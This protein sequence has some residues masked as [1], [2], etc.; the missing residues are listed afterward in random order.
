MIRRLFLLSFLAS[1]PLFLAADAPAEEPARTAED[2][3]RIVYEQDE[4]TAGRA[5]AL[6]CL[7]R[8]QRIEPSNPRIPEAAA[9]F[10]RWHWSE[11]PRLVPPGMDRRV[12]IR[13]IQ[14][15][16]IERRFE[17]HPADDP[18]A[19][20]E[21][22]LLRLRSGRGW[23][24][25]PVPR[26]GEWR[27]VEEIEGIRNSC[28]LLVR[29][30]TVLARS[31]GSDGLAW[32]ID[33]ESGAPLADAA[34]EVRAG[35]AVTRGR[36]GPDGLFRFPGAPEATVTATASGESVEI[37]LVGTDTDGGTRVYFTTD[38][39]V[40]RPGQTVHYKAVVREMA[41]AGPARGERQ[42]VV[43][44]VRDPRGRI[45]ETRTLALTGAGSASGSFAIPAEPPI[46]DYSLVCRIPAR[47]WQ[48]E[49]FEDTEADGPNHWR[50]TFSVAAYRKPE[51][52]VAVEPAGRE[53]DSYRARIRVAWWT[54]EPARDVRVVWSATALERGAGEVNSWGFEDH[55]LFWLFDEG[56]PY[57]GGGH[58]W[59]GWDE[60][61]LG[62]DEGVTDD[63]GVMEVAVP[64]TG[65]EHLDRIR[66]EVLVGDLSGFVTGTEVELPVAGDTAELAMWTEP[67]FAAPGETVVARARVSG[68]DG[69]PMAGRSVEL[70]A[71]VE[72]PERDDGSVEFEEYFRGEARTGD[73]GAVAFEVPVRAAPRIRLVATA[74]GAAAAVRREIDVAGGEER[75]DREWDAH[76]FLLP[77][78]YVYA[79]GDA[80]RFL[81]EV[82]HP[83][84]TGLL[85]V[86]AGGIER[87]E[88]VRLE[89]RSQ[90]IEVPIRPEYAPNATVFVHGFSGGAYVGGGFEIFVAPTDRLLEVDIA[91]DRDAYRPGEPMRIALETRG[92]NDGGVPAEVEL[93]IVDESVFAV[94]RDLTPDIRRFFSPLRDFAGWSTWATPGDGW[95]IGPSSF[96]AG[97]GGDMEPL[98][99][100]AEEGDAILGGGVDEGGEPLRT[101][102][103][104]TAYFAAHVA[105]GP[106]G[107]ATVELPAPDS[108]A[109]WRLT[110]RAVAG[111]DRFGQAVS[112][113]L[114]RKPVVARIAAP[115]FFT[116]RDRATI[117][118]IV[119]SELA[120][121][122]E[123]EVSLT[124]E[125]IRVGGEPRTVAVEPGGEVRV[126]FPVEADAAGEA[127]LRAR[128]ISAAESDALE[129]R[130]P[131]R[132]HATA[133]R[134]AAAGAGER[135][136]ATLAL[137][138]T[139]SVGDARMKVL[140]TT[141]FDAIEEALP[142]LAGYPYGC[143]EQT[144]SRF[145][146]TVIA[147]RALRRTGRPVDALEAAL[148]E[149][150]AA[151]LA[152][153]YRFQH[154]DGGWGWWEHDDTDPEMTAYVVA[155]LAT[156]R[157]AGWLVDPTTLA[158]GVECLKE[159]EPTAGGAMAL[160]AA[161][162]EPPG[163]AGLEPPNALERAML[164]LAGR[165][166]LAAGLPAAPGDGSGDG[167][168]DGTGG[169]AVRQS[170]LV[171]R[172]L[173]AAD[174][175]DP[176]IP[177]FV[178]DL[179]RRR[180][181]PRWV[182][183]LDSA[184]AV[185]ALTEVARPAPAPRATVRVNGAPAA[186]GA[187]AA[188]RLRP[189]DNR[190]EVDGSPGSV[191][192]VWIDFTDRSAEDVAA[193]EGAF[194]VTRSFDRVLRT[195]DGEEIRP[196]EPGE[197][198]RH[199]DELV[200]RVDVE[201][202][203]GGEFVMIEA[204][205]PAGTEPVPDGYDEEWWYEEWCVRRE[206]RDD[207]VSVAVR[208][209][210]GGES[211]EVRL[212]A[213]V[214]GSYH[215]MPAT[216]RGMY[217][218]DREGRSAEARLVVAPR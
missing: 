48:G 58:G 101:R 46:G 180:V 43:V 199:G 163:L 63:A 82:P 92:G 150:V 62:G 74:D 66:F 159:M 144:M 25:L 127:V 131:V 18:D 125:G 198:V 31:A 195:E 42:E 203:Q 201:A 183:T 138:P 169:E 71:L 37:P 100:V 184:A 116:E 81:V 166:D 45:L 185:H 47:E 13:V 119:R 136:D 99:G 202:P 205:F 167:T 102:F 154:E 27:I 34:V 84:L 204:P 8:L 196:L 191:V 50:K 122:T 89:A 73:D 103:P 106:D 68:P 38:R 181:G 120:A 176:R 40:Y 162:E 165:H 145:L 77:D 20:A 153:L 214:P 114:T 6:E 21:A 157:D 91:A 57:V 35:D 192:A 41:P 7:R 69:A 4:T 52:A 109:A 151:G 206:V 72:A 211:F 16:W 95:F 147:A 115:R 209:I 179:L 49:A 126:E 132:L 59:W 70:R 149:M 80:A 51:L 90:V 28:V 141:P 54:G 9:R 175:H 118:V 22:T 111:A 124:A 32:V 94:A 216:A 190:V 215:V 65:P 79:P 160:A 110:A 17:V 134:V 83:P 172:A 152:R 177:L 173:A 140:V 200:M 75:E 121:R 112:S 53:G 139:A 113:A 39:P 129:V 170:A 44:D 137:P 33:T 15:R 23:L 61:D 174:P 155:G 208:E 194:R 78:R 135:F 14:D 86:V 88:I 29:S 217:A 12:P 24:S 96:R 189:G 5:R 178:A 55:P 76:V 146:P 133:G 2:L 93:A 60:E 36:T 210:Y 19:R 98:F 193:V 104:D 213:T 148:P 161:G 3:W 105:T 171:I 207:R 30:L 143:V 130:L 64:V 186:P 11:V 128:A 156:A 212:R 107:R 142:F 10:G 97:R 123:L 26:A 168:G 1:I 187:V 218:P 197:P 67:L 117:A 85:T 182:S 108:L 87:A 158:R 56:E 188:D 164:V